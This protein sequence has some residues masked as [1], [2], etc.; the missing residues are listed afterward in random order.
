MHRVLSAAIYT[1]LSGKGLQAPGWFP[2]IKVKARLPD[3]PNQKLPPA[4]RQD[5][6][7][8][9]RAPPDPVSGQGTHVHKLC[10]SKT[11]AEE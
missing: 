3:S 4:P 9:L 10:C 1:P 8:T 6:L 11:W 5:L 7:Q 2:E